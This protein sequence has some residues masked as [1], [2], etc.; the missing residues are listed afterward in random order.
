MT[1]TLQAELKRQQ[2][3]AHTAY[4]RFMMS[5]ALLQRRG[6]SPRE[7]RKA[8][9][10]HADACDALTTALART[11]EICL[12]LYPVDGEVGERSRVPR[13][14]ADVRRSYL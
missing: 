9:A 2:A 3:T 1:T 11:R 12:I 6:L 13:Y 5:A 8:Q 7:A 14:S 10:I 4:R